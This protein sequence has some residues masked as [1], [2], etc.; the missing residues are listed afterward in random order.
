MFKIMADTDVWLNMAKEPQQQLLLSVLEELVK[1]QEVGILLPAV[2]IDEFQRNRQR[3]IDDSR[4]SLSSVFKR[5]KDAV[6][7]YGD[8]SS[9]REVLEQLND[10]DHRLPTLGD[11]VAESMT[12]I[13]KLFKTAAILEVSEPVKSR[14]ID[15]ALQVKAPFHGKKNSTGDAVIIEIYGE[16]VQGQE[17]AGHRFAFVTN[18]HNDFSNTS[19][20]NNEAH[21]DIAEF[22]SKRNSNYFINI[23]DALRMVRPD[24]VSELMA[25]LGEWEQPQRSLSELIEAE[26]ELCDKVWYNRHMVRREKIESGEIEL[27]ERETFPS[28]AGKER[29]IQR[30]IWEGALESA[31]KLEAKYGLENLGPWDNFE[32]GMINGKLSAIRWILG[33]EWDELYT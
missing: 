18:N 30:D 29:P 28:I 12:R 8:A 13:E 33:D 17:S 9:K 3:I 32:W 16:C 6:D 19:V 11:A 7:K 15:R 20:N 22:F 21:P 14:V 27:V 31:R 1:R 2:V 5:V 25:E 4:K 26:G 10:I 24:L 23:G